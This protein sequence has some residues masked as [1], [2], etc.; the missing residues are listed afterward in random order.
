MR[1]VHVRLRSTRVRELG[2]AFS[3]LLDRFSSSILIERGIVMGAVSAAFT[4]AAK[5]WRVTGRLELM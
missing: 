4:F 1:V 5:R 3:L 2:R